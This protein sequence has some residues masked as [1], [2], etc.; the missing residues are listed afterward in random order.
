MKANLKLTSLLSLATVLFLFYG[1]SKSNQT[2]PAPQDVQTAGGHVYG[3]LPTTPA[4]Y[5]ALPK[6]SEA[7]FKAK[8]GDFSTTPAQAVLRLATPAVRDQGQIGSCTAFCGTEAYEILYNYKFGAFPALRSPAFL[9][10]EERVNIL[11]ESITTDNGANMVNIDQALTKYGICAD[12]L[13]PYPS[14]HTSTAYKTPPTSAAISDALGYKITGYTLINTGDV[15]AVKACLINNIPVMMG[16]NV[17]DN[18]RTYQYFEALNTNSNTYNPLTS[19]GAL[20]RGV[21]LLGGHATPIVGY[22][23]NKQAF[24][25]QNSWG[26]AWGLNGFYYMPYSVFS[27]TKI[28]P[29][30]GVYYAT[31]N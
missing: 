5:E 16:F 21:S 2:D 25:V 8:F 27:S 15:A 1:C 30:G 14:S 28:V 3:L 9:Y 20:V 26:T 22:D 13:M 29:Q 18:K 10:Y 17:Y 4:E 23:D 31:L 12:A 6:Y 19:T 11:G 7:A 24:L